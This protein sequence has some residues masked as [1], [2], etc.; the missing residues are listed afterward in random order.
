[1]ISKLYLNSLLAVVN[2]RR[3]LLWRDDNGSF[4]L[5][6]IIDVNPPAIERPVGTPRGE[7]LQLRHRGAVSSSLHLDDKGM[8][9]DTDDSVSRGE[10]G[11]A[12]G[13]VVGGDF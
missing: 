1:V 8:M 5:Q 13:V 10:D 12:K 4:E 9:T 3:G 6:E 2:S 7:V 11:G